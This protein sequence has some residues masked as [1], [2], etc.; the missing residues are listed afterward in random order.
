MDRFLVMRFMEPFVFSLGA[1][2]AV[3]VLGDFFDRFDELVQYEGLN[4]VGL[5]YF[6]L[7]LPLIVS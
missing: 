1:F 2:S 6:L 7:K 4:W 3:Y 5:E